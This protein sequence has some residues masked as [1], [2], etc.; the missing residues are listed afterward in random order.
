MW[1][2]NVS[3]LSSILSSALVSAAVC[4]AM[5]V[6]KVASRCRAALVFS[7]SFSAAPRPVEASAPGRL[8]SHH[9]YCSF[10]ESP[11]FMAYLLL[12]P[13]KLSVRADPRRLYAA[14]RWLPMGSRVEGAFQA[15]AK[16]VMAGVLG[17]TSPSPA[18]S[19]H[20]SGGRGEGE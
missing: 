15:G 2:S 17:R 19:P 12:S 13:V 1:C 5:A 3:M 9:V 8:V 18:P 16:R 6:F 11:F 14:G 7:Y 20:P 10:S 4:V